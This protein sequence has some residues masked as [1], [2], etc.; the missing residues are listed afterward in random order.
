MSIKTLSKKMLAIVAAGAMT[1]GMTMPTFAAEG[2]KTKEAYISKTYNT[3]VGKA[4]TFSFSAEQNTTSDSA[5]KEKVELN[6]ADIEFDGTVTTPTTKTS[7]LVFGQ[8][9]QAGKYEYTVKEKSASNPVDSANTHEKLIMSQA[10]YTV[11]VYV[12]E[13][14]GAYSIDNIIVTRNKKDDGTQIDGGEKVTDI[15]NNQT[16]DFR[17]TNTYVQEA[18][19]GTDPTNPGED[20]EQYGSLSVSKTVKNGHGGTAEGTEQSFSFTAKFEFPA[21]TDQTTFGAVKGNNENI[22]IESDGTYQFT[23]KHGEK[24]K[25]TGLPVGT[26]MTVTED[27]TANYRGSAKIVINGTNQTDVTA[28]QYDKTITTPEYSLGQNKNTVDVTNTY[29]NVPT[30]GIIMNNLPYVLMIALCGAALVAFVAF[31]R[32]RL[33]K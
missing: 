29:N 24:M 15:T 17:F 26:K 2:N 31:K 25:F 27:G 28:S 10:V 19:T 9:K 21:G 3:Q 18:G 6:I 22:T 23:L 14:N 8:F 16:N 13:E 11:D 4:E 1:V 30:M 32:R 7:K 20:Y 5:I 33:Q 12:I